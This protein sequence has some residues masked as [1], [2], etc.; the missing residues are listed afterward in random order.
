VFFGK[1]IAL[2]GSFRG[3]L[4]GHWRDGEFVGRWLDRNGEHGRVHGRYREQVGDAGAGAFLGR[5]AESS[6]AAELPDPSK[7]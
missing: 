1:Y 7:P 4:A 2:D 6:C 3:I 5:W